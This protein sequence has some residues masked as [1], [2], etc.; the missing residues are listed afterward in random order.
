MGCSGIPQSL[1]TSETFRIYIPMCDVDYL[2]DYL[3]DIEPCMSHDSILTLGLSSQG[4]A[5]ITRIC[6]PYTAC[7][8][9]FQGGSG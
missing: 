2:V 6:C 5:W 3:H 8:L 9:C 4:N 1:D 7:C